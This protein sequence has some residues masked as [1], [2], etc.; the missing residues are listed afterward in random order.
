VESA[1]SSML[2]VVRMHQCSLKRMHASRSRPWVPAPEPS[3][4]GSPRSARLDQPCT[5]E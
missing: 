1:L 5:P 3:R 4:P 2:S